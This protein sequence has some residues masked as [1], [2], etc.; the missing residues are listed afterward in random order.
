MT[1]WIYQFAESASA[2]RHIVHALREVIIAAGALHSAQILQLSGIGPAPL[3]K[4]FG[5]PLAIELPGVGNNLQDHCLVG[6]FYPCKPYPFPMYRIEAYGKKDNNRSYPSPTDL[7]TNSTFNTEAEIEYK[8]H[9][10][11]Q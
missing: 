1:C 4:S 3:L 11:G 2:P 10:T 6:T 7:T 9:K 8:V 5:I